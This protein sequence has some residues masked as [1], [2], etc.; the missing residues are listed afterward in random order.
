[1]YE[2]IDKA[3][4]ERMYIRVPYT[5]NPKCHVELDRYNYI[6]AGYDID[7][8]T[9]L[10][11]IDGDYRNCEPSNMYPIKMSQKVFINS[12]LANAICQEAR[13]LGF[14]IF[15]L[16]QM[17]NKRAG[18][19]YYSSYCYRRRV[20][21]DPVARENLNKRRRDWAKKNPDKIAA[22]NKRN[23]ERRKSS[24]DRWNH[25]REVRRNRYRERI[26]NDSEFREKRQRYYK[27]KLANE[28]QEE[29][30]KSLDYKKEWKRSH[31]E[32]KED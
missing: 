16:V 23:Y 15:E 27:E 24:E 29:R 31:K 4:E 19:K 25:F 7:K 2:I 28:T 18:Y 12:I 1:M 32:Q 21:S 10:V 5:E 26:Q 30:K 8:Y 3:T 14:A 22:V 11:H 13:D 9:A 17:I 6:N 20:Q